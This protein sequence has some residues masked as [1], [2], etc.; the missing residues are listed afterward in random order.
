M[1]VES[2]KKQLSV[3]GDFGRRLQKASQLIAQF[4]LQLETV[5]LV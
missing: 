4:D 2:L 3:D 5:S 1:D